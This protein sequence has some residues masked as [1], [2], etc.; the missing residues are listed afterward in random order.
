[1]CWAEYKDW[2][3]AN[4]RAGKTAKPFWAHPLPVAVDPLPLAEGPVGGLQMHVTPASPNRAASS[5]REA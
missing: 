4:Q 2:V 3:P 1:M 5:P